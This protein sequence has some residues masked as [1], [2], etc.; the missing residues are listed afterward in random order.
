MNA[1]QSASGDALSRGWSRR[2]TAESETRL[3]TPEE[4]EA[5]RRLTADP[6]APL[7]RL[8]AIQVFATSR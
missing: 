2:S 8:D 7:G 3:A 1:E 5:L 6:S 4:R